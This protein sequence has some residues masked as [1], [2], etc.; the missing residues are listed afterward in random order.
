[1]REIK[2]RAWDKTAKQMYRVDRL[3]IGKYDWQ[4]YAEGD[5]QPQ[6]GKNKFYP[7]QVEI[8]QYT[9]LKDKNG[10]EIYEGDIVK[11]KFCRKEIN[12]EIK[13]GEYLESKC[14]EYDCTHYGYY[15]DYKYSNYCDNTGKDLNDINSM[16]E[17]IGNIYDNPELLQNT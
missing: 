13:F 9:G 5:E 14:D 6:T 10:V 2:F 17:V 11:F 1:M 15:L 12:A 16:C 4:Q 8:M 7:S 3:G